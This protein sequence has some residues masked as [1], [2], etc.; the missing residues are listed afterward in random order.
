ME[1]GLLKLFADYLD[2][3]DDLDQEQ[4]ELLMLLGA[5]AKGC[6][7]FFYDC[8]RCMDHRMEQAETEDGKLSFR[9]E[10][11]CRLIFEEQELILK[12]E[13]ARE[14]LA[15]MIDLF[16]PVYPLGTVVE[17]SEEF[18]KSLGL[19]KIQEKIKVVITGRFAAAH[20]KKTYF[21]YAGV[22][23]PTGVLKKDQ[24]IHFTSALIDSVVQEGYRDEAEEAYVLLMKKEL[25]LE[26]EAVSFGFL[27]KEKAAE[28]A[29]E[30]MQ[31]GK[32]KA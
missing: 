14:L 8:F 26:Q 13:Q 15:K 18:T 22:V 19:E 12:E 6:I 2:E 27:G 11:E 9:M 30:V 28:Y 31:H 10:G 25:L 23:Y 5:H 3:T 32:E 29:K 7:P 17:L 16:E 24:F 1:E 21:P 20:D 4:K